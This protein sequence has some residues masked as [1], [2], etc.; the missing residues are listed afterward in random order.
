MSRPAFKLSALT[1]LLVLA[2]C[3]LGPDYQRPQT[4]LPE[5]F[6]NVPIDSASPS[7]A[8]QPWRQLFVDP[9]LQQ[10]IER[11][12]QQNRDLAI[13]AQRVIA[14]RA[15][16]GASNLARLPQLNTSTGAERRHL[17][18]KGTSAA[19]AAQEPTINVYQGGI[20]ATFELDLW[21][22][23][24]RQS[25][26]AR[27][28]LQGSI[29]DQRT[30]QI[31]LIADIATNYFALQNLDRQLAITHETIATRE[32]SAGLIRTRHDAGAVSGLDVSQAE[33]ELAAALAAIPDI[34]R[35]IAATESGL[36]ILLGD[37]K[38][39]L[40]RGG[41]RETFALTIPA[42][43]PSALLER[44]P[45][46]QSAEQALVAANADVGA[47]KAALFPTLSLTGA[48]GSESLEFSDLF[49]GPA[50]TWSYGAGLALPLLNAD[51]SLY[52]VKAAKAQREIALLQ[53]Q[54]TVQQAFED[55]DTALDAYERYNEQHLSLQS[56]VEAYARYAKLARLRYE[57]GY[58]AYSNVLDAERQL[59]AA[60][61]NLTSA[62]LS[63]QTAVVQ[64]YKTLGGGWQQ[65]ATAQSTA[66]NAAAPASR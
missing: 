42:G 18:T 8:D 27:A 25:E 37:S 62:R 43:L 11:G 63:T 41:E 64:L 1:A 26:A 33:A 7:L 46:V 22:R 6:T 36:R 47:S 66:E 14:A 61:L 44:R 17:S 28:R 59:F 13:A 31:T 15:N 60:E 3:A 24:S 9:Q 48:L 5:T 52:Q 38:A 55:V 58:S 12:L 10:L 49:T 19:L 56:Q 21:G 39:E 34:E 16:A 2:G 45:D 30:V 54:Q 23:L 57:S 50:R 35:Q 32:H 29:Y 53:Y 51:R 40:P 20:D 4:D 65:S